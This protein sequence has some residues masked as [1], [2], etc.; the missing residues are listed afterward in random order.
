MSQSYSQR[1]PPKPSCVDD[2]LAW[3]ASPDVTLI[4]RPEQELKVN[5]TNLVDMLHCGCNIDVLSG[6]NQCSPTPNDATAFAY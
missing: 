4:Q 2:L 3:T 5:S 1:M 6:A